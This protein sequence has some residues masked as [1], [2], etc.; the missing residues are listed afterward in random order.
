VPERT[1]E[2]DRNRVNI[3]DVARA[4]GVSVATVSRVI[5][6]KAGA[7][8]ATIKRIEKVAE[9]LG[10][11]PNP[12]ARSLAKR[13][14]GNVGIISPREGGN[15]FGNPFFSE[16]LQ[17]VAAPLEKTGHN[18][19]LSFTLGQQKRLLETRSVDGLILFAVRVG[20]P[21]LE[22]VAR[23]ELP[24]VVVG[25]YL[26]DSPYPCARPDDEGGMY[27][28]VRHLAGRG[29]TRIALLTGPMSSI[30][31]V[32]CREGYLRGMQVEGLDVESEWMIEAEEYDAGASFEVMDACLID[33]SFSCTAIVCASDYL[34]LG[35][36]NAAKENGIEVPDDLSIIGFGNTP[37]TGFLDPPLT[38]MSVDL[39]RIGSRA[40]R[41]LGSLM[42]GKKI[43]AREKV[44]A[45][46]LVER[47]SVRRLEKEDLRED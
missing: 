2:G 42:D 20:D 8:D 3:K 18:M 16:I 31:S 36:L 23:A 9:E 26:N 25:S 34:A 43:R 4:A 21:V 41:M 14:T 28:A 37:M 11:R 40:A 15:F 22:W 13:Q 44:F 38:T 29:H 5:S 27:E 35:V 7:G 17:G 30:K 45:T 32:R 39:A 24:T 6:G 47:S 46:T 19:V 1:A 33:G 10:Y 12:V